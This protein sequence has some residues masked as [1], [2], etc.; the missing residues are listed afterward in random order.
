MQL[1]DIIKKIEDEG[2]VKEVIFTTDEETCNKILVI[3]FYDECRVKDIISN[4]RVAGV[5]I[6]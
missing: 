5:Y 6:E 4:Y 2:L 1:S 3:A